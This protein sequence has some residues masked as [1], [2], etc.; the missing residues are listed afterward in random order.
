[1]PD[2]EQDLIDTA[3]PYWETEAE[4]SKRFY[5]KATKE[6]HIFYLRAQLWKELNPV[7]GFFNGLHK[8][9]QN[10]VDMYP[11]VDREIDRHDYHFLLLQLVQ[12][13]NHYVVLADIFEHLMGRPISPDDT[14]QLEEERKLGDL[15]RSYVAQN[16]PLLNAAVGFTEGGGARLFRE[17]KEL[18]GSEVNKLTAKAMQIIF[19][20]EH[21]HFM[22][23]AKEA[24]GHI[25]STADLD[26]MKDAIGKISEQRV[27]MR[28]EMFRNAM[29]KN[30]IK[31]FIEE[32]R[33]P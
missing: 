13:F 2:I 15:R 16:D 4:I 6:D 3:W 29:T 20:D 19:D 9:L 31:I 22:E 17:G 25:N 26:R 23:Q 1:M 32:N 5:A 27:W 7:D 12:E 11:K 8:E 21:D 28:S 33:R 14:V 30:E 24:V 18:S 10:A